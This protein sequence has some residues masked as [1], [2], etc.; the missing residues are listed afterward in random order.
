MG[1]RIMYTVIKPSPVNLNCHKTKDLKR[2]SLSFGDPFP[3]LRHDLNN[4]QYSRVFI[5]ER[6]SII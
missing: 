6:N 5:S 2:L 1:L 4:P 3:T